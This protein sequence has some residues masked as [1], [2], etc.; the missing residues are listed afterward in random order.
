MINLQALKK[1]KTKTYILEETSHLKAH[2]TSWSQRMMI[3]TAVTWTLEPAVHTKR[4]L[5]PRQNL[6]VRVSYLTI[7]DINHTTYP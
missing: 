2:T 3:A 7:N 6:K 5:Q 4:V 1:L